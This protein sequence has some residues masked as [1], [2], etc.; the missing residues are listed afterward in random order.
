M[1]YRWGDG[2]GSSGEGN[3]VIAVQNGVAGI[4]KKSLRASDGWEGNGKKA[5]G[6]R[7]MAGEEGQGDRL[8]QEAGDQSHEACMYPVISG[9]S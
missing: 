5:W 7:N 4:R 3:E 6:P 8:C 9:T 2:Q 1:R